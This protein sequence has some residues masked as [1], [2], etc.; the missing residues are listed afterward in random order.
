MR[1]APYVLAGQDGSPD[2]A[3]EAP[4]GA[5][6]LGRATSGLP[7]VPQR[8]RRGRGR[9]YRLDDLPAELRERIAVNSLTGCWEWQHRDGPDPWEYGVAHWG[10]ATIGVHRLVY[11]LLAGPIPEGHFMDHVYAWGCRAKSCCWPAHLEPVLPAVNTR[12]AR[13]A[14]ITSGIASSVLRRIAGGCPDDGDLALLDAA[15]MLPLRRP[16][17]ADSAAS[18]RL[19]ASGPGRRA[20]GP[21][22]RA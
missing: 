5:A 22:G 10:T 8:K 16:S 11:A 12:R 3:N 18:G 13:R 19:S 7:T 4:S 1:E 21:G 9:R 17:A 20:R 14:N 15:W 6:R 2:D